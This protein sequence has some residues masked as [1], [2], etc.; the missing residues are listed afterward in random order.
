MKTLLCK[1][2]LHKWSYDCVFDDKVKFPFFH[3]LTAYRECLRCH[4]EQISAPEDG[5][6]KI[7]YVNRT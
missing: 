3:I 7:K 5:T 4:K 2:G 6:N 1:L